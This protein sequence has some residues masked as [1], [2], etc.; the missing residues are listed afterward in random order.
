MFVQIIQG[1]VSDPAALRAQLDKWVAEV[2]P[3]AVGWLGSTSGVTEDGRT[4]AVVRFE[5]EE[6]AQQN[7]DRPEQSAWWEET[8]KLFTG[9]PEFHNSTSVDVD[10]P[11]D[12]SQAGFVQVMQGRSN[13]P[14]KARELMANDDT[15]WQAFRPEILGSVSVG[16][17]GDAWTMVMYFTSEE[18]AREGEAKPM[19]PEMEQMM[20]EMDALT[21]GQPEFFDLKDPWMNA[22]S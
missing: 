15:D 4:V 10:T 11:G 18:A 12:P 5:S 21:V 6:A 8:A 14:E 17:D 22:P 20:K 1:R 7:S 2:A 13:N 3:N 9:E 19:P 16:H